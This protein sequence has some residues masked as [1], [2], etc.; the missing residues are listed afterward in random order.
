MLLF[1]VAMPAFPQ[2]FSF[3][4]IGG[5]PITSSFSTAQDSGSIGF[6]YDR[7]YVVGPT[8]EIHLPIHFSVEVDALYRRN[9][10]DYYGSSGTFPPQLFAARTVVNDLQFPIL[11]KYE[12]NV[13]PLLKPF[14]SGGLVFRHTG[15]ST[16]GNIT[17]NSFDNPNSAGVA[18][19]GGVALKVGPLRLS[20]Q[21]RYT[22]W[23]SPP[24]THSLSG[25]VSSNS[26][27]ADFL[28]AF[29]F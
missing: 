6:A 11:A 8:A 1:F 2:L 14:V 20:P 18:I 23:P 12:V 28:V 15:T 25:I 13:V 19:G 27:Q 5:V 26:N 17:I 9:G 29:T 7:L 10:F 22:H 4:V 21:I 3:G 24:V 16:S